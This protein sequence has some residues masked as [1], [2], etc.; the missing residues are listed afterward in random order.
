MNQATSSSGIFPTGPRPSTPITGGEQLPTV[1]V[2]GNGMVGQRF[3]DLLTEGESPIARVVTFCEEPVPAYD[4]VHLSEYFSGKDAQSL[5]LASLDWYAERK[6]ELHLGERGER[7]D[8]DRRVVVSSS[9]REV[10]YDRVVL[11]TGSSAYVPPI[12]GANRPGVFVYRTLADLDLIL[13]Y[14]KNASS[15]AVIGGGLLGLEAAKAALDLGLATHV[16]EFA[17]RLMPRQVDEAGARLLQTK[18]ESLG[19]TVHLNKVTTCC[20]GE[21]DHGPVRALEFKD[22]E[23]LPVDLVIVSAGIRPRDDVA[24]ASGLA[25]G[26]RGGIL[27]NDALETSDPEIYAIGECALHRGMIY[28]LVGPGYQMAQVVKERLTSASSS[29]F[30]GADMSAKLKLLGV[31]VASFGD[32]LNAGKR[33]VV[34]QD[35]VRGVYKK[36]I[37]SD[38]EKRLLGGMLV[39]EANEY[40]RLLGVCNS[41]QELSQSP[42]EL[43]FGSRGG[44]AQSGGDA[45]DSLQVCS[46]NGVSKGQICSAIRD[47]NALTAAEIKKCTRAGSGCGGC[48]PLVTDILQSELMRMGKAT[49]RVLC[50]HFNY[51]RQE[52]Y[53][54]VRVRK[55]DTWER[56]REEC[57]QG[58][59]CEVCKPAVASILASVFNDFIARHETLQD[60]NDRYL[61]NMQ[62][63]GLYSIVPRIPGGE[64]TPQKLMALG[65]IAEKYG[66]YTKITGGQRIDLFGAR[67]GQLPAIWEE[68]VNEGFESGHAY[69]KALR[70]VKSCVGSTW[71]RYGLH[72]SVGFAIRVE[73]RYRGIRA[74][75]KLK[76]AVSGC[77]REC[78][79]AQ[80]KDFGIIATEK[81][82]NLYVGG[83]GGAKPRHADLLASDIDEETVIKYIDRFLMFYIA[84]ADRLTRTSTW[85]E[86]LEGGIEHLKEVIID[87]SLG[88]C[89]ELEQQMAY[90]VETYRCE[91]AAVV[92]NPEAR[93]RFQHFANSQEP[94]D[95]IEFMSER[96][97]ARPVDWGKPS[98]PKRENARISLP[99]LQRS[100][101]KLAPVSSFPRDGGRTLQYGNSQIAVFNFESRGEWYATQ[102]KCPHMQDMVLGRGLIGDQQGVPKVACPLHK[103]TFS[104]QDGKCLGEDE[105][106]ILTFPVKVVDG[107]VHVELPD[108]ATTERMIGCEGVACVPEAAAAE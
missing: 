71:C 105:Y 40:M 18:I 75:H 89:A 91:W 44:A 79:E 83:N 41:G 3:C 25:C 64:I 26:P 68:L 63:K 36:L 10:R 27:V 58:Y 28:G 13:A 32:A 6:I 96:S 42:E 56:V 62:R 12:A 108:E 21:G 55:L 14:A 87:D 85:I 34:Y 31:D 67:V 1:V 22:G 50:E 78:A 77:V 69:G 8:R 74:P 45:P 99:V 103:K 57:G 4:R 7:V 98:D 86:K 16:V 80:S 84:T 37:L 61:A 102:N 15:A 47:K 76:S 92:Q 19:I 65:R 101:V 24:R 100:W 59:G 38:D 106:R 95:S 17:S 94:D 54:V 66:L 82:W 46:C 33:T 104:L 88:I 49:K 9:G 48:V 11:A 39:G 35:M 53:E 73:E 29:E 93:A 20:A 52:L 72:D 107:W 23:E 81:G 2:I 43:L 70:T 97:Q 5:S 60:T 51:T 90:L 30:T